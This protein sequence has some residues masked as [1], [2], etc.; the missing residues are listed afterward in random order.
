MRA[1][2]ICLF[3]VLLFQLAGCGSSDPRSI[4]LSG[5][6]TYQGEPIPYG[7]ITF[8]P[9]SRAGNPGPQSVVEIRDGKYDTKE[10]VGVIGGAHTVEILG[11]ETA[12]D[13]SSD[14]VLP[15]L[16]PGYSTT[17]DLPKASQEL[18]FDVPK[19]G[20]GASQAD[21]AERGP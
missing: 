19:G 9:D 17:M 13:P 12:P 16:F 21:S 20:G 15:E 7:S 5:N 14:E 8:T 2:V 1:F 11:Y 10:G 4:H 18:N 6:A 3:A